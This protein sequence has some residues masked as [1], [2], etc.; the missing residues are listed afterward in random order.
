M[1]QLH[2]NLFVGIFIHGT[3]FVI[4]T[5]C[6]PCYEELNRY[7]ILNLVKNTHF[8]SRMYTRIILILVLM[9]ILNVNAVP[10]WSSMIS[11]RSKYCGK[12][13]TS[14]LNKLCKGNYYGRAIKRAD[15]FGFEDKLENDIE[16]YDGGLKYPFIPREQAESLVPIKS[17]RGVIEE[18]CERSCSIQELETYCLD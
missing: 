7:V 14:T 8:S 16:A 6:Y 17:R 2:V 10:Y 1:L 3:E 12:R 4:Y 9:N 18:C 15:F 11:K 5:I 13:L